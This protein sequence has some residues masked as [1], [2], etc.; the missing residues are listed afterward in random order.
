[1]PQD[2]AKRKA[3]AEP[4]QT[5]SGKA[6]WFF[7]GL[8]LGMFI[9][10][11]FYLWQF[12]PEDEAVAADKPTSDVIKDQKVLE[13]DYDFYDLFPKAE[14]PIV[15]E[16]DQSGKKVVAEDHYAYLLQAGSF[17]A[18]EDADRLR[19]EL[20]LQGHEAMIKEV[21]NA[22]GVWH[23]VIIG[24]FDNKRDLTRARNRLAEAN[25]E[26]LQLRVKL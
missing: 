26:S 16:Y 13:I 11:L 15:E 9:S 19:A 10:F 25:I 17:K 22:K 6:A 7:T 20:I 21:E 24:P 23:R 14:V 3:P 12:V 5:G 18:R 8:L 4:A 1:M 2:F